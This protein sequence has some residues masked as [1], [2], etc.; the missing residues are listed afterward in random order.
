[1]LILLIPQ[2]QKEWLKNFESSTME[3]R[4]SAAAVRAGS[5]P[6]ADDS[7]VQVMQVCI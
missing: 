6:D 4:E 5:A 1:M 2:S 3:A 7:Y